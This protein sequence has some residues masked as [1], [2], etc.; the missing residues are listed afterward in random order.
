MTELISKYARKIQAINFL[1][2]KCKNCG[3]TD[4]FKLCFHHRNSDD[5]EKLISKLFKSKWGILENELKKCD[6]LCIN[7]H[8]E[9]HYK[10]GNN[11]LNKNK[12]IYLEF[13]N[14]NGCEI[15]GYDK[16]LGS[17]H[18]HHKFEKDFK[19]SK[20]TKRFHSLS[21]LKQDII[22]ELNKCEIICGNCHNKLHSDV[23]YFEENKQLIYDKVSKNPNRQKYLYENIIQDYKNGMKPKD[24]QKKFKC[25]KSTLSD[26]LTRYDIVREQRTKITKIDKDRIIELHKNGLKNIE[27]SETLN[28][29]YGTIKCITHKYKKNGSIV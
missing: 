2:G 17:L 13:K 25:P 24:I 21:D 20:Y 7:C 12:K 27:I 18:F 4:I 19:I 8:S 23:K 26:I 10:D 11:D 14:F 5:K 29:K 9:L 1:G 22:E 3:E 15:C 28:I 6:L 16:C